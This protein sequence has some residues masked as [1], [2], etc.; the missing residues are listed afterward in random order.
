[1]GCRLVYIY[2][3]RWSFYYHMDL[4]NNKTHQVHV[5]VNALDPWVC[6]PKPTGVPCPHEWATLRL[7]DEL[8]QPINNKKFF[9]Q[10]LTLAVLYTTFLQSGR[11]LT[12]HAGRWYVIFLNFTTESVLL[13]EFERKAAHNPE[14]SVY[15]SACI[16]VLMWI[17]A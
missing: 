1:M 8:S 5:Q 15:T 2:W 9:K 4:G 11:M 10:K 6:G 7:C 3:L 16:A 12:D 13:S 17:P 14:E